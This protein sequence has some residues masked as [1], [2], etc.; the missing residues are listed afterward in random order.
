MTGQ[1]S[2]K[3]KAWD[4]DKPKE[5]GGST[6]RRSSTTGK[7]TKETS[8]RGQG[9]GQAPLPT[10]SSA[11][12]HSAPLPSVHFAFPDDKPMED[13]KAGVS[14]HMNNHLHNNGY[15]PQQHVNNDYIMNMSHTGEPTFGTTS[16]DL[17]ASGSGS[18]GRGHRHP[19][20]TYSGTLNSTGL[21]V[22]GV[23]MGGRMQSFDNYGNSQPSQSYARQT[24]GPAVG[25]IINGVGIGMPGGSG[26][27]NGFVHPSTG[28]SPNGS[29]NALDMHMLSSNGAMLN[30]DSGSYRSNS[31]SGNQ[32][33][34]PP[35][36]ISSTTQQ[37]HLPSEH[38]GFSPSLSP[39]NMMA[40][41]NMAPPN[42]HHQE[43]PHITTTG[44]DSTSR[45]R[46]DSLHGYRSSIPPAKLLQDSLHTMPQ[47][48][49]VT[50]WSTVSFFI[51]LYLRHLHA[52][53]R[54]A[55][56]VT[57]DDETRLLMFSASTTDTDRAQ[58]Q[59]YRLLGYAT[60]SKGLWILPC[61]P[62]CMGS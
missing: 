37:V 45:G 49:D 41:N 46:Q 43:P 36:A 11:T 2:N 4:E 50:S 62:T 3:R 8:G 28:I 55:L 35:G 47:I 13:N 19:E 18:P 32:F 56:G 33:V 52:L 22:P 40:N 48:E 34:L 57:F 15:R 27:N 21:S 23:G 1:G 44:S 14:G 61:A 16:P 12:N 26:S 42:S 60:R 51:S 24:V 30:G 58:T 59:L 10:S 5:E 31:I 39:G 20:L 54:E 29:G 38:S 7:A 17:W 25:N 6:K 9:S 53:V